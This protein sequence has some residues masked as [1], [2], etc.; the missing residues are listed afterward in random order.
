MPNDAEVAEEARATGS[1]AYGIAVAARLER[2]ATVTIK[3]VPL[4]VDQGA[5]PGRRPFN[6]CLCVQDSPDNP[7]PCDDFLF[8]A[9]E[10]DI[11]REYNSKVSDIS[12]RQIVDVVIRKKS[13]LVIER[14]REIS[15][16]VLA[17]MAATAGS[18]GLP[19]S[20]RSVKGLDKAGPAAAA[21]RI[22]DAQT[23]G[24]AS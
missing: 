10:K 16:D 18:S 6:F 12:G 1:G 15:A 22:S 2:A 3:A 5:F 19:P 4:S 7:C 23:A 8:W 20:V 17:Q 24:G 14:A 11:V 9:D 21:L 13:S